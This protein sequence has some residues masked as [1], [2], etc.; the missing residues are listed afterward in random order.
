MSQEEKY[1]LVS[2]HCYSEYDGADY[3]DTDTYYF[4]VCED[5]EEAETLVEEYLE[6]KYKHNGQKYSSIDI[7]TN[8]ESEQVI[9]NR[10]LETLGIEKQNVQTI[11]GSSG[12]RIFQISQNDYEKLDLDNLEIPEEKGILDE[13]RCRTV[14]DAAGTQKDD[15]INFKFGAQYSKTNEKPSNS[16]KEEISSEER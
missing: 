14:H 4:L 6:M 2:G 16:S 8:S 15:I 12:I 9:S 7:V 10:L 1:C 3:E 11:K 5:E 13:L